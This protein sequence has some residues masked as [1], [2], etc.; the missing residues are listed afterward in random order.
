MRGRLADDDNDVGGGVW[1]KGRLRV[2]F[3]GV[4]SGVG[5]RG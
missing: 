2:V 1:G 5:G 4:A 3:V